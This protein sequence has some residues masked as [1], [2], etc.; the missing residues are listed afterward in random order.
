MS[1]FL[2][3]AI[4]MLHNSL[5]LRGSFGFRV[6][7]F[8]FRVLGCFFSGASVARWIWSRCNRDKS[9]CLMSFLPCG[10]IGSLIFLRN[11][12]KSNVP[13]LC[14]DCKKCDRKK[15]QQ[16]G[17]CGRRNKDRASSEVRTA[18]IYSAW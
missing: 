2:H 17:L 7:G 18:G 10:W 14:V 9:P 16:G 3:C 11:E 15:Q 8:V 6:P 4:S 1:E 12:K 13:T 5:I